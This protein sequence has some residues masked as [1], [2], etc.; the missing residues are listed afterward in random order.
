MEAERRG[1]GSDLFVGERSPGALSRYRQTDEAL[2]SFPEAVPSTDF[3]RALGRQA[4]YGS[5]AAGHSA[6]LEYPSG[7]SATL[8][9]ARPV[10]ATRSD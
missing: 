1:D 3:L 7:E 5:R 2:P 10:F 6:A 4:D 9:W 8:R